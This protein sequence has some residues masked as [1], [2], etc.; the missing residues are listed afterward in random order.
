MSEKKLL[1][2]KNENCNRKFTPHYRNGIIT[3]NYCPECTFKR[4][5]G[6]G[7][8]NNSI[9]PSIAKNSLKMAK[10]GRSSKQRAMVMAD[11]WFSRYIRLT[12][13]TILQ[14]VVACEC[15]TCGNLYNVKNIDCGHYHNR[16][17]KL[18]RYDERNARPQCK[19]CNRYNSGRHTKFGDKLMNEI[20][21]ESFEKL[22]QTALLAGNDSE[23][24]YK[25]MADKFK[26]K[27]NDLSKKKGVNLWKS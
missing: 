25:E 8:V 21:A 1:I 14:G 6:S 12:H 19:N 20:G 5:K 16:G 22:R 26:K 24:F 3:S 9:S 13:S 18:T 17:N 7:M 10:K 27:F 2:C 11:K 15:Y 4:L 23:Q